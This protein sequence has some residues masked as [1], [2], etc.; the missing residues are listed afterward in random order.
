MRQAML[1][2]YYYFKRADF[3]AL[4]AGFCEKPK[5]FADSGAFSAKS[6]GADITVGAYAAWVRRWS[7]HFE[8]YANLDVIGDWKATA[9][10]QAKLESLG[11]A[12]VP[13]FHW[14]SPMAE[15]D[16]LCERYSFIA[17]GGIVKLPK[18]VA[19]PWVAECFR[20]A[21]K[22]AVF[23]GFGATGLDLM[24]SFSWESFDSSSWVMPQKFGVVTLFDGRRLR[25]AKYGSN[26][27][28][29]D[30]TFLRRGKTQAL[31]SRNGV[32]SELLLGR[33]PKNA[34]E[35][36]GMIAARRLERWL[37][38]RGDAMTRPMRPTLYLAINLPRHVD[39]AR[40]YER[41]E[42]GTHENVHETA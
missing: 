28:S 24:Q 5:V 30:S 17:L 34:G 42:E 35:Y 33:A 14:G 15:L 41:E 11:L 22:R 4:F 27:S 32:T 38:A 3:D 2:S 16:R 13:V 12:P 1:V 21:G 7:H 31:L 20:V 6:L 37:Q 25:R 40:R 8:H 19:I 10:N 29:A 26:A 39:M 9:K 18:R 23:H 36:Q